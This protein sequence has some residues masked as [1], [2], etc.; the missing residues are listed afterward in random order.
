MHPMT[1]TADRSAPATL[2][3]AF[4]LSG[5]KWKL[6][7]QR[8][9]GAPRIRTINARDLS[10]V[11][12][13][14]AMAKVKFGLPGDARVVACYEAG[15]DGF[16]LR[17]WLQS[18]GIEALVVDP[19]SL[20]VPRRQRR[21][22][23][24]RLDATKLLTALIRHFAGEKVWSVVAVPTEEQEDARR[25]HRERSRLINERNQHRSRIRGLLAGQGISVSRLPSST[26]QLRRPWDDAPLPPRL[27]AELD[28]QL[29][30]LALLE[31][32]LRDVEAAIRR[33]VQGDG[34]AAQRTRMFASLRGVGQLGGTVLA[35]EIGWRGFPNR[36]QLAAAVGLTGTPHQS[37]GIQREQGISKAGNKR[38]RTLMVELSWAWLRHQ[39]DSSL[40]RWFN[41]RY[42]RG[43]PR[44][45]RVG[46]VALARKLL[47]A[48]W[49]FAESGVVPQGAIFKA[50]A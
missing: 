9:L 18:E 4:E 8:Q 28:R 48:L 47:I 6:A 49:Q 35:T 45:R 15:Q 41:E 1:R 38:V 31:H 19:A 50:A 11:M 46:I 13:E 22:K 29:Q 34:L 12:T 24:D 23:T 27:R 3:L 39:P 14:I 36:R 16:W 7:F 20:D 10:T 44:S 32:Q 17:R 5:G 21:R 2:Y 43:G 37:G 40:A 25:L 26:E 33:D 30:R 42:A